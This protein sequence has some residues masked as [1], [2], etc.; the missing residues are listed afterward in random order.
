METRRYLPRPDAINLSLLLFVYVLLLIFSRFYTIYPLDDDWSYIRAAETFYR[1][2]Q[3]KFTP[4]TSP[5]LVFQILWGVAWG[6]FLG[7]SSNTLIISTL[8]ISFSGMVFLYLLLREAGWDAGKSILLTLLVVVNPFSFPL[9]FTFFTDQ[10]FISLMLIAV[11]FYYRGAQ[12]DRLRDVLLGSVFTA[13]AVLVRQQGILIAAGAGL[14]FLVNRTKRGTAMVPTAV[15]LAL[16]V[17]VLAIYIYWFNFIHG[18]TY[19]S[20]Q[21]AQWIAEDLKNPFRIISKALHR[22]VLILEFFGISLIPLSVSLLPSPGQWFRPRYAFVMLIFCMAGVVFFLLQHAGIYSSV[23]TW[24]NGFHFAYVSEYG[25]R[26]SGNVLLLFYTIVDFLAVFSIT[27]ILYFAI[28]ER[29]HIGRLCTST[30][31]L[32]IVIMG[33][34][35]IV[36]LLLIRYKFTR[37][38]L[39]LVPFFILSVLEFIKHKTIQKKYFIPL[40][41]GYALFSL[42]GTQDFLS[43][44]E[45]RWN[46]GNQL[47]QR[48]IPART[49]SAG[50]PWDCW[51]NMDYCFK[52]PY[53]IVPQKYDIPWWIEELV[54]AVDPEYLIANSPVPS[55][56]YYMKYFCTDRYRVIYAVEYYSLLYLKKL[57]LYV[58]KR[59][60]A[61]G[62]VRRGE[63]FYSF[64][65][66]FQ[67]AG[68]SPETPVTI[69]SVNLNNGTR[70][71]LVQPADTRCTFRLSLPQQP[72]SIRFFLATTPETGE[73]R[74]DGIVFKIFLDTNL[75]ENLFDV[76]GMVGVEQRIAFLKP[77]SYFLAS[78]TIYLNY[79]DTKHNADDG[80]WHEAVLDMSRFSGMTVD[81]SFAVEPG[82]QQDAQL[83]TG[84]W[85]E[86]VIETY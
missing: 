82:P 32:M 73:K 43:W 75:V 58:L 41:T 34:L 1:T 47:L 81:L 36:Y 46:L 79:L 64:I 48:G 20:L 13:L 77:R 74:S 70:K 67:G 21:Q 38:Y 86:P 51:H 42:A 27:V 59:L 68:S 15:S 71:A 7:F 26:G 78:R 65:D 17:A 29:K 2:G 45:C 61:L 84:L 66:N 5:S 18:Q 60:D 19:S 39:V 22:P 52:H 11:F 16:P 35:Q 10:H 49:L 85:G 24:M 30:P 83:A 76:I 63:V 33:L 56:F 44:N 3:M 55:G 53:E 4:W 69:Q 37:Y 50:F 72:C 62:P 40:L 9:F 31:L 23:Y 80:R 57:K 54:P 8:V 12:R 6:Y 14:Y 28:R 25:Y